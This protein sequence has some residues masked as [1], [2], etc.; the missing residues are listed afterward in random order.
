METDVGT[1]AGAGGVEDEGVS[2]VGGGVDPGNLTP[3]S[4]LS[5]TDT[6]RSRTVTGREVGIDTGGDGDE[7]EVGDEAELESEVEVGP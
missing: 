3:K 2:D 6:G 4:E 1:R 5:G 7:V